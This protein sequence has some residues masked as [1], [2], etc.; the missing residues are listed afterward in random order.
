MKML[1]SLVFL[2][3]TSLILG[4]CAPQSAVPVVSGYGQGGRVITKTVTVSPAP[5][6]K[7]LKQAQIT[8]EP[9]ADVSP[10]A[11][12]SVPVK[13]AEVKPEVVTHTVLATDTVYK[14]ARQ[15]N[16][17]TGQILKD[18]GFAATTDIREGQVLNITSNTKAPSSAWDDM[19]QMLSDQPV[20][21]QATAEKPTQKVAETVAADESRL[22]AIE[23]AAGER[24]K[25]DGDLAFATYTVQPKDTIYRISLKYNVSV[26]DI[27]AANDFE[28]PQ[29][30][31]ANAL[32]KVPVKKSITEQLAVKANVAPAAG[33]TAVESTKAPVVVASE[34]KPV[35]VAMLPVAPV[36]AT[37]AQ[38][39]DLETKAVKQQAQKD[40]ALPEVK[41][42]PLSKSDE[43]KAEEQRG[44]I[45]PVAAKAK[46]LVWPVHG[47]TIVKKFG[48]DGN[49]VARTGINIAV[50]NGTSVLASEDGTVLYADDGLKIY[51]KM[52]LIR[53]DNGMVSAYAH[54]GY[55]LVKKN[56]RVKKGQ[57]IA[58]SGATGN[59][60]CPQLHFE[61]RQHASAIDPMRVL[62][63]FELVG[64]K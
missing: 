50:P 49:G 30:L 57:V 26:L 5:Q 13:V 60:D 43:R 1:K 11:G 4:A 12:P 19:K 34:D 38:H 52:V 27:M 54:N 14:L 17:T 24:P 53:H 16:T 51:G 36:G 21:V 39:E 37:E 48:D 45:D 44:Q 55:L 31:K 58:L 42:K 23:P 56:E 9:L 18:N 32:I 2:S 62:P 8:S 61:L 59:V 10:S 22:A 35:Q 3:G 64:N 7:L 25:A 29:D 20:A 28:Q 40:A 6:Q 47:G 33:D 46:G 41:D 15:Y 63:R